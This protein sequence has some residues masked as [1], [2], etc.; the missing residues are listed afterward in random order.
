MGM[1]PFIV[2]FDI[3]ILKVTHKVKFRRQSDKLSSKN[4]YYHAL[5]KHSRYRLHGGLF[6]M[7][8]SHRADLVKWEPRATEAIPDHRYVVLRTSCKTTCLVLSCL[9]N[10][11]DIVSLCAKRARKERLGS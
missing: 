10:C 2:L 8:F 6:D 1:K 3:P 9:V 7:C 4:I 11:H 5:Y